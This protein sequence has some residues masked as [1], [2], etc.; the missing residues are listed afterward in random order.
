MDF[1]GVD[2]FLALLF[3]RKSQFF[4]ADIDGDSVTVFD[5]S[6]DG[7]SFGL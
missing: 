1:R 3:M 6:S 4:P 2:A 7:I 5:G